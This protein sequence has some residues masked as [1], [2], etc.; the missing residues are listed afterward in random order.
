MR[1]L[2]SVTDSGAATVSNLLDIAHPASGFVRRLVTWG[3]PGGATMIEVGDGTH[4]HPTQAL[5]DGATPTRPAWHN[6]RAASRDRRRHPAQSDSLLQRLPAGHP[7][8]RGRAR[9]AANAANRRA[10]PPAR[11]F[12]TEVS[13]PHPRHPRSMALPSLFQGQE[14]GRSSY[15]LSFGQAHRATCCLVKISMPAMY[16]LSRR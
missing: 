1:H 5:L 7:W 12:P 3:G 2:L 4:E 10:P 8:R 11:P 6:R 13:C 9:R 14:Q 16:R 15:G